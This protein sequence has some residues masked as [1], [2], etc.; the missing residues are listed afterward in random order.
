MC[1]DE[2]RREHVYHAANTSLIPDS[3]AKRR[4][5]TRQKSTANMIVSFGFNPPQ[6]NVIFDLLFRLIPLRVCGTNSSLVR[7]WYTSV[8]SIA[9]RHSKSYRITGSLSTIRFGRTGKSAA[10][11]HSRSLHVSFAILFSVIK[12]PHRRE[13][14]RKATRFLGS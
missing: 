14:A 3:K 13:T 1:R 7:A 8:S 5:R 11:R 10:L 4:T 9:Q 12:Y 2:Q 6:P